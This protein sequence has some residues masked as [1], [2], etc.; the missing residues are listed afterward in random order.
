MAGKASATL[1]STLLKK[2]KSLSKTRRVSPDKLVNSAVRAYL[3]KANSEQREARELSAATGALAAY[4]QRDPGYEQA[5]AAFAADEAAGAAADPVE[6][7]AVRS[8]RP[9]RVSLDAILHG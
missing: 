7:K 1:D 6:G 5:I 4:R 9:L 2:L 8:P 3:R